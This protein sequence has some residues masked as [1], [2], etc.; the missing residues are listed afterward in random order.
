MDIIFYIASGIFVIL[1]CF[2][3]PLA[4][5]QYR[6]ANKK[7]KQMATKKSHTRYNY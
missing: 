1:I 5:V 3:L 6:V 2:G 7:L 4:I